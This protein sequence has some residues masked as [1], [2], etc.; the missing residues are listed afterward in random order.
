MNTLLLPSIRGTSNIFKKNP[1]LRPCR[2][3]NPMHP[4]INIPVPVPPLKSQLLFSAHLFYS[5]TG[6]II[7]PSIT[8]K[9][10]KVSS[11][12]FPLYILNPFVTKPQ[13]IIKIAHFHPS[14]PVSCGIPN[15]ALLK[16]GWASHSEGPLNLMTH[17]FYSLSAGSP[18]MTLHFW[19]FL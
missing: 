8:A 16:Y 3:L 9:F 18:F 6:V 17:H 14:Q 10:S 13:S 15:E 1:F 19:L 12:N 7:I 2:D 11:T 4:K 5:V